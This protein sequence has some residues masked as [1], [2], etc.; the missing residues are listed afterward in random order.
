ML[1][2]YGIALSISVSRYSANSY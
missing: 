1:N 2:F